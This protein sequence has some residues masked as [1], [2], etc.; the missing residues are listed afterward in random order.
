ME[1]DK[2]LI[3]F[4]KKHL[5]TILFLVVLF[6]I[7]GYLIFKKYGSRLSEMEIFT[8]YPTKEN[9]A[10]DTVQGLSE[11][12][13]DTSEETFKALDSLEASSGI[14][15]DTTVEEITEPV[16]EEQQVGEPE[17]LK[18]FIAVDSTRSITAENDLFDELTFGNNK[19]LE[20]R[21]AV[22][23]FYK[24]DLL[25]TKTMLRVAAIAGKNF[26]HDNAAPTVEIFAA[27]ELEDEVESFI[28]CDRKGKI[29]YSTNAKFKNDSIFRVF[30]D[31]QPNDSIRNWITENKVIT[32]I[33]IYATFG[34]IG[35]ILITTKV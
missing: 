22:L 6:S 3:P 24:K 33:P 4:I 2:I 23:R 20:N 29:V 26:L 30:P 13:F 31:F 34:R 27:L 25:S 10:I 19:T 16:Q 8:K 5:W 9:S 14:P 1:K 17:Q 7:G 11:G 18:P 15:V 28:L 21:E 32:Q 35:T 12:I